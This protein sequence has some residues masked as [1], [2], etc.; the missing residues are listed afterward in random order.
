MAGHSK[1]KNIMH[2]KGA[3]D[4]KRAKIFNRCGREIT[5]AVKEGGGGD[6]AMNPR[7]RLAI[8][9]ARAENMPKDRIETAIKKGEGNSETDS[10]EEIRYEG[11]GPSGVAILVEVMTD[12]RNRSAAE[13][14]TA[15]SKNGGNMGETGSVGF[16]FD[17]VGVF[18]YALEAGNEETM[19]ELAIEAGA[20]NCE[21]TDEHHEITCAMDAFSAVRD[22]LM[23]AHIGEP[24]SGKL[25]WRAQTTNPIDE[26][27]ASTLFKLIEVL[28]DNDD[29]QE[30][31]TNADIPDAIMEKL[32]AA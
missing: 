24:S 20:D 29:V 30:V 22:A 32:S 11:Y 6:P 9:N 8:Q 13:I 26:D 19:L 15:F 31:T 7:L 21:T 10:L 17:R 4:K 23:A 5:V 12:N 2:R 27:A 3:Q 1:F 18:T 28:E 25:E 16:M 14:R